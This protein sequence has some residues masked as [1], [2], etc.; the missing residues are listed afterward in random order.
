MGL[1]AC[2]H[3]V[4]RAAELLDISEHTCKNRQLKSAKN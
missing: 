3:D 1:K 2:N 4:K